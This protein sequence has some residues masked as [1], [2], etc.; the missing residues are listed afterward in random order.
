MEQYYKKGIFTLLFILAT[1]YIVQMH[2]LSSNRPITE[3]PPLVQSSNVKNKPS[4]VHDTTVASIQQSLAKRE[5]NISFDTEKNTLQSPNRKQGLRAYYKP[6]VLTM[7]NRVDSAGHDFSLKLVNEG[8]FADGRQILSAQPNATTESVDNRLQIKHKGFTEEFVNNEEGVRQNFIID[9]API[10]TKELQVRLSAQGLKVKDMGNDELHFYAENKKGELAN[11]LIYKDITCWDADGDTLPAT[12][13]YKDGLVLLSV[14]VQDAVYPVTIDPIVVNGNPSNANAIVES[15]Q[16]GAQAGYAVSSAGDV[17]GDGYSDV[18]VGAP[19]FDSGETN[20]G[21]VFVYHGSAS[22]LSANAAVTLQSNQ[23]EAQFGT[24]VSSAGD[25]NKD[26]YSDVIVGAPFY[27]KGETKEGAAMVYYGSASG[28]NSVATILESNQLNAKFG[29]A[30]EGLGDVNGDGFSDVIV[31]APLFDKGQ[32]DEGAAFIYHGSAAGINLLA[33][34]ILE[35]N[36]E[37]AQ[38][39]YCSAGAGDVNG[40]GYNDVLV[41]AYAYDKGHDNEGA[42]FVHLGSAVGINNNASVVLEG[43][44]INAQYGWSAATAGDVNGDGYSDIMVGSYLYDYGQTNEGAVFVYHGSAQGIKA[45]AALRLESNQPEAKQGI[46]V[47]CAGDVNGD[48]YSD[49]MIGIWQY[50]KGESNEGAVVLHHGSANGLISS[51][52]S[53]LESNQADAGL[54]WSV[55]SAGDVNG[56]GYSDIVIGANTYDTGQND[57]GAAFIWLGRPAGTLTRKMKVIKSENDQAELGFAV[58]GAGDVNGD[59]YD[60]FLVG[61]PY[62]DNGQNDEGAVFVYH[63]SSNG[64]NDVIT[65]QLEGN[66]INATFGKSV[67]QAGDVNGDG[68]DDVIVGA[69]G[70]SNQQANEG[71]AFVYYGSA[72]GIIANKLTILESNQATAWMGSSVSS[73]GD[74][75]GD[76]FSDVIVGSPNFSSEFST[77]GAA[78]VFHGSANGIIQAYNVKLKGGQEAAHLGYSVAGAGDVNGDGFSDVILGSPFFTNAQNIEGTAIIFHGS[79]NGITSL[80]ATTIES[81]VAESNFGECVASA[82]DVNGDGYSDIIVGAI[83]Y[84]DWQNYQYKKGAAYVYYGSTSGA[85]LN[86]FTFLE[87]NQ[88]YSRMG[89]SVASAGDLNGDGY[90]DIVMGVENYA[91]GE[92]IDGGAAFI[93]YGSAFKIASGSVPNDILKNTDSKGFEFFGKSVASAGDINGDGYGDLVLGAPLYNNGSVEGGAAFMYYGNNGNNNKNLQN[94][95][96]LYNSNLTTPINQTQKAKNDFGAG[97]YAKSFLGKNNGKLIWETKAKGQ[98]FSK[99]ANDV[100]TNSTLSSG[101]QNAYASLGLTGTELKSVIAKQGSSTK[102]RVRVKYDPALA[103]TGQLYG[104]WR[105]LPAY[106]VGNSIAPAPE[107]V[108]DDMSETVKR[109]VEASDLFKNEKILVYPNPAT[110]KIF[111]DTNNPDSISHL[112]LFTLNGK[113]IYKTTKDNIDVRGIESGMHILVISYKD[114]SQTS[115]KVMIGK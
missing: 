100:I 83:H 16:I 108:V 91:D 36:Q 62:F 32:V 72:S 96:R 73:A 21:V 78:F 67:S 77:E 8:I 69:I 99:G 109:K 112:Q 101:S 105:Y 59:G 42:V 20:E 80:P 90:G 65:T 11:S 27:T 114:G 79:A 113:L 85:S 6:G 51:P 58:A 102:V 104:P 53:T 29:R 60:D 19:L 26:G 74:V 2:E 94:N 37:K 38:F 107:D 88:A 45:S 70:Y 95:L 41:G 34:N 28:L 93:Y 75:N 18:L 110:D 49:V 24:S 92:V 12:L 44:Q 22:G 47:A 76:G 33:A 64:A 4:A 23:T 3:T 1:A 81:N 54:G 13:R 71:A 7:R 9:S 56:D 55:K 5:Y 25:L 43:N 84:T 30:V 57:E 98:G 97:L 61:A 115:R 66:Q 68:F 89:G 10:A 86:Q 52:A 103:L 40:D 14:N 63:G 39:G 111:I 87:G 106:L 46:A 35:S 31:G 48:G 50:D 17:N 15:N 82:G